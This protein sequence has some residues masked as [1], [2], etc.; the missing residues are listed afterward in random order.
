M[1]NPSN[2]YYILVTIKFSTREEE[3][4]PAKCELF[5]WSCVCYFNKYYE[6]QTTVLQLAREKSPPNL[7]SHVYHHSVVLIMVSASATCDCLFFADRH[8]YG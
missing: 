8:G 2:I 6:L 4:G 3:S 5:Y 7:I 1:G